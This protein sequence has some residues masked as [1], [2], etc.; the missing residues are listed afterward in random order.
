MR[1]ILPLAL[2]LSAV[3]G[4]IPGHAAP[5]A[6][7]PDTLPDE[8]VIARVNDRPITVADFRA[9]YY[10]ADPTARPLPDS[11][12]RAE[13]LGTVIDKEVLGLAA[14][15]LDRPLTFEDRHL[16]RTEENTLLAA[17]LVQREVLDKATASDE[18]MM[19]YRRQFDRELHLRQIDF[20]DK[21]T[22]ERVRRDLLAGR[23]GWTEAVKRY[24]VEDY[25]PDGDIGWKHRH[26]LG[27]QVAL[28]VF[29]LN[30]GSI[31]EV[32]T[33]RDRFFIVQVVDVRDAVAPPPRIADRMLRRDIREAKQLPLFQAIYDSIR[34]REGAV[35][36]STNLRWVVGRFD[37]ILP[38]TS[39]FSVGVP[40]PNFGPADT[41]RVLLRTRHETITLGEFLFRFREIPPAMRPKLHT[42][43]LLLGQLDRMV[44]YPQLVDEARARGLETDPI[45]VDGMER[46]REE[47]LVQ[48]L[49]EDS[50]Q[51]KVSVL[52]DERRAY[53]EAHKTEF[54]TRP[55]VRYAQIVRWTRAGADSAFEALKH[56]ASADSI[57]AT[58]PTLGWIKEMRQNDADEY[59][60]LLF[61][62]LKPGQ[63]TVMG[64]DP[65]KK[66]MLLFVLER[67]EPRPMSYDEVV[68]IVDESL[69]NIKT[70]ERLRAFLDR[71]R[72]N[73][74][75]ES[76]PEWVMRVDFRE[77]MS[78]TF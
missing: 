57:A 41:A 36:D 48:H 4:P 11:A 5:T 62:D 77:K 55:V 66:Y 59:R 44:F 74:R 61:E 10:A 20:H 24:A 13:F 32:M 7:L 46:R 69:Y 54:V 70:E 3:A 42:M 63:G 6:A 21:V 17:A 40:I 71:L 23:I 26:E 8:T 43:G 35:Y 12:G 14:M 38:K 19:R 30:A 29:G 51:T 27:G 72:R 28:E 2:A 34:A 18:E 22:A 31:S 65:D 60:L 33:D 15:A 47:I 67:E 45:V 58:D 37:E 76:H 1:L 68:A 9:M 50:V 52:P 25:G 53:Y 64:P 78:E 73:C 39:N 75:I 56:G 16:L 49:F